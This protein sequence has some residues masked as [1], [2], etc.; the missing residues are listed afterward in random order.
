MRHCR[1]GLASAL[2]V[3]Q[4]RETFRSVVSDADA[5]VVVTVSTPTAAPTVNR[6]T[7]AYTAN[8]HD[9]T[10]RG[11][12]QPLSLREVEAGGSLYQLGDVRL[13]V[14]ADD[15]AV[16]PTDDSTFTDGDGHTY[17]VLT[18]TRDPLGLHWLLVGRRVP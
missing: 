8:T 17:A 14:M 2:D 12:L 4:I 11:L 18:A 13:R 6:A 7:G 5:G 10:A 16:T 15:L 9:D 3:A 1:P